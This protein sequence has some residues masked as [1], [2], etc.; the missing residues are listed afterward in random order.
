MTKA[1]ALFVVPEGMTGVEAGRRGVAM[2][3]GAPDRAV[4]EY[5]LPA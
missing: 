2:A 3:L 1:D 4:A 5:S